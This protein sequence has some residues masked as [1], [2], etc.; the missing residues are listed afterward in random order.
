MK[1]DAV[2]TKRG[3]RARDKILTTATR[4]IAEKGYHAVSVDEI[5]DA[6]GVNKRM[7]YHY[8][9]SK[10]A[11]YFQL[12]HKQYA[13]LGDLEI[14]GITSHDPIEKIIPS[15]VRT[16]F[17]FLEKNKNFIRLL[18][19]ENLNHGRALKK[20]EQ[21]LSKAPMI[22]LLHE[23]IQHAIKEGKVRKDL[24]PKLLLVSLIGNCMIYYSNQHTLSL[25][26]N[27][28]L[29]A[30]STLKKAEPFVAN[31]LLHGVLG[32]TTPE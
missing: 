13:K 10:E 32:L 24:N 4:L 6:A 28:P 29:T 3:E 22:E 1:K 12:L 5:V 2:F 30:K 9:G 16:Y 27:L 19:W 18:L 11:L 26:L 20:A 14:A 8:F 7:V 23:A 15:V 25:A 17:A 31:M 21:A